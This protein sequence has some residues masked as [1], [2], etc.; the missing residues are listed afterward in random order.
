MFAKE[1]GV[2][3][4]RAELAARI[5][6]AVAEIVKKRVGAGVELVHDGGSRSQA[7]P[8]MSKTG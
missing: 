8:L 5:G 3:V 7:T 6:E 1:E 4:D 2:P